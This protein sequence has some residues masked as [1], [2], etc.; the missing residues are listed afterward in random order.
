MKEI[1]IIEKPDWVSWDDIHQ[2]LE[3]AHK[4][5]HQR[6][7]NMINANLSGERIQRKIGNGLCVVA[8]DGDKLIGTQSVSLFKGDRWYSKGKTVA[9]YCLTGILKNYQ[10]CGIKE[11][12]DDECKKIVEKMDPDILQANTAEKNKVVL[13]TSHQK[14][15]V[16]VQC[17]TFKGTDYYSIFFAKWR[18]KC[19]YPLWYCK[20]R[21]KLSAIYTKTRFK[22][23]HVERFK[24]VSF[25]ERCLRKL[26][27]NI[28][29]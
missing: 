24:V 15:W 3:S 21:Y 14:G 27:H 2:V 18:K 10:G 9:H 7:F 19:P 25:V 5:N 4:V 1:K 16:D 8:L 6:G 29:K 13:D 22:P 11:M 26:S 12:L 20:L 17:V 23:G 28:H